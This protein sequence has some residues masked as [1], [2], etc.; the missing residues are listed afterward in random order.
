MV[1]RWR[2][3]GSPTWPAAWA[4]IGTSGP[5]Q[6]GGLEVAVAG[7]GADG[8]VVAAVADVGQVAQPTHVDQHRRR[9]QAQ[10]HQRQQRVPAGHEL[11]LVAVLGE[12]GD[13]LVGESAR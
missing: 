12:Q 4:R 10:L 13:G 9:G 11:G 6:V 3:W 2:T 5:E 7:Q 1:P 8:D